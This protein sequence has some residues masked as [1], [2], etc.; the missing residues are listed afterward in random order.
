MPD[1]LKVAGRFGTCSQCI[2]LLHII[3]FDVLLNI[4]FWLNSLH[5]H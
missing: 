5:L 2:Q 1:S 4:I 3:K